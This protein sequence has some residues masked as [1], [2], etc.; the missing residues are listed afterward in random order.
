MRTFKEY[1]E[2]FELH[3][4]PETLDISVTDFDYSIYNGSSPL[5]TPG[6]N[7]FSHPSEGMIRL[8][9]T[10]IHLL[11]NSVFKELSSP[12]LYGY[13]KDILIPGKDNFSK[14]WEDQPV[15]DP[16]VLI[17]T[18]GQLSLQPFHLDHAL[19][20]FSFVS[21]TA[22]LSIVNE[23]LFGVMGE[24]NVEES[25]SHPIHNILRLSYDRLTVDQKVAFQALNSV[26]QAGIMMPLL[27]IL[28][29]ISS[30]EYVKGLISL[31]M[32]PEELFMEIL[33]GVARVQTYLG[34]ITHK[35]H[36]EKRI[37]DLISAGE[38][39]SIEFKSTLR[40]D[41][42]AGKTNPAIE[43]SCLKTISAFVNSQGERF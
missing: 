25:D 11:K 30:V 42:R 43:R 8:I 18:A 40:W 21:L 10:D 29:K 32:Q 38:G 41:I 36:Q 34:F 16:F 17:K 24:I 1:A 13:C 2:S 28:G 31:K 22:L 6:G 33:A 27:L 37:T 9:L 4:N 7:C 15:S 39:D 19:F 23:F 26:Q 20:A 5:L 12:V 3:F 14:E 35:H